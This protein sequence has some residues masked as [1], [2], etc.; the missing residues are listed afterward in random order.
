MRRP[1]RQEPGTR[2]LVT[3]RCLGAAFRLRPDAERRA[4]VGFHL[5]RAQARFPGVIVHAIVQMSN[6]LHLVVTDGSGQLSDFMCAFLSPLAKGI[7]ALDD[8]R[9]PV[10]ERR[11]TP[12]P[13]VDD[14]ALLDCIVYTITNP[15]AAG[16]VE[17]PD[18]WPG[19][20][21]WRSDDD[22][23]SF[24]R[25]RWRDLARARATRTGEPD[26]AEFTDSSTV[27][28]RP[29]QLEHRDAARELANA[30]ER[31]LAELRE[32]RAGRPVLGAKAVKAQGPFDAPAR[33]EQSRMPLCHASTRELWNTFAEQWRGF[34]NAYRRASAAFRHGRLDVEFPAFSFRPWSANFA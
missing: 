32:E 8:V 1:R 31:R 34:V 17:T 10:F 23:R 28:V 5:A 12:T 30:L 29:V 19:L 9:G 26:I 24:S 7:N 33:P 11:Y 15:V 16:L 20:L 21:L 22:G 2:Y 13:I 25:V 4:L 3:T 18:A 27:R 6:H 14:D